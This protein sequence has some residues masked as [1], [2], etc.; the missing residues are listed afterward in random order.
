M[1]ELS[2]CIGLLFVERD[3]LDR[4]P[5]VAEAVL[6]AFEI[7]GWK[8][9]DLD[10]IIKLQKSHGLTLVNLNV[11]P[12]DSLLHEN[13]VQTLAKGVPKSCRVA[14]QLECRRLTM[15]LQNVPWRAGQPWYSFIGNEK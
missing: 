6:L 2:A 3:F 9:K 11:D 10:A 14:R 13:A 1:L 15:H 5:A 12:A 4:I 7:W 8:D